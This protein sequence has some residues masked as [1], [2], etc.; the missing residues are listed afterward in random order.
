MSDPQLNA[1]FAWL[2]AH[3]QDLLSDTQA[4]LR[5]P[6]LESEAK[7][8]APFGEE[9]RKALDLALSLAEKYGFQTYDVEGYVG[10]AE[11]GEG[12]KMALSLGHLDVVPVGPGWKHDPFGAEVDGEYLYS[13]G[14]IDD[15]GPTMASFY[16]IR[17]L[18]ECIPTLNIRLRQAFGCNEESG[19]KCIERY[20]ESEEIPWMGVAPDSGWPLYHV[21][22]R[23]GNFELFVPRKCGD[24]EFLELSG[25]QRPNIVVDSCSA[26]VRFTGDALALAKTKL[27][28]AW[29]KN[30]TYAWEGDVLGLYATGK[31]AHGSTPFMGDSAVT[32]MIRF[33][34]D[35]SPASCTDYMDDLLLVTHPSGVGTGIHG[36]DEVSQDLTSN[37][38]IVSVKGDDIAFVINVRYPVTWKNNELWDKLAVFTEDKGWTTN[39]LRDSEG[40]Y[41]PLDHPLT[42]LVMESYTAETGEH[43]KPGVMGG[44]TYARA[45]ANTVSV[46]TGWAGDGPAHETDERVKVEHLFKM[47]RIYARIF[48]GLHL[49]AGQ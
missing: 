7:P 36:C 4:M 13:R 43:K 34:R 35:L 18:K 21:E 44:G 28:D 32:R 31:A 3:E 6:S 47:S 24:V 26:K 29:D 16:A 49:L 12:A 15:K 22:K 19:F 10:W 1:V 30:V 23:I 46:G 48:Y 45:I 39:D 41:F 9:N 8:N 2:Q 20:V 27:E 37:I 42:K 14:A 25:G 33:V 38:G 40:L 11:V 5:I 17:A